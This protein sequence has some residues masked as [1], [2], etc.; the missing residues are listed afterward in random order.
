[1]AEGDV[2]STGNATNMNGR[3][4]VDDGTVTADDAL[5]ANV[6]ETDGSITVSGI[7]FDSGDY[8]D[9]LLSASGSDV[10]LTEAAVS[11]GVS[12]PISGTEQAG[13]AVYVDSG[14]LTISDSTIE[15]DGAGR[16]TVA[17]TGTATMVVKDS[18]IVA[19]GDAGADGN[20]SS[21]S[22]PASNAGLLIS[23]NSRANFSVGQTHTFYYDSLCVT[24]GWAAL[25]TDSA[26][27][28]GLEFVGVNTEALALHGGYGIYADTNCRDYLYGST[29][30]S[31]EVGAIISNNGAITVGSLSD[32]QTATTQDGYGALEYSDGDTGEDARTTIVAGRND[33]QLHSPDMM[34]EG[35]S[36]YSAQL[37][38]SHATLITDD[39]IN[40][41]GYEYT[42]TVDGKT[43]IV[44]STE[45]YAEKY[46]DAVGAYID[47]VTGAAIL[48]KST[49]ADI[50]LDDVEIRSST[51]VALLSTL[52]SDS[53]SR[54]LKQDVGS[55]VN[56]RI[57][58][59]TIDGDF[60]HDDYQRDLSITLDGATL[61]G[62]V[63][64]SDAD[65]WNVM[66]ADYADD[67]SACWVKLD[68]GTYITN[69]HATALTL[70]NGSV[71]N[72]KE[73]SELTTLSVS[74]DS[75]VNGTI[76]AETTETL[77]DGTV[78]YTNATV[79]AI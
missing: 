64:W 76:E 22:E 42:S 12:V 8:S 68:A 66:W 7:T 11:M 6:E 69:T 37:S 41:D 44:Q 48:V 60:I 43:Y 29:L 59:S 67:E 50:I 61:N 51:G 40:G 24:D 46:G 3:I 49:S 2:A 30:V 31:A 52:N 18:A 39:S 74:A 38:L 47:Y 16:Y 79:T 23:G 65:E 70:T 56:V 54:Y 5:A 17:A 62:D 36:D 53:M 63:T 33:F 58:D 55:G 78:I 35:N 10:I 1:M 73:T 4:D 32:A 71:W 14:S 13:T 15:V 20:T 27:G 45:D 57:S 9:T 72:V 28:S 75:T 77:D 34:G 21:V 19:G 26:T 25:S